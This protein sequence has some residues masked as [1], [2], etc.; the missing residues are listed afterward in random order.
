MVLV[1]GARHTGHGGRTAARHR[2]TAR[3]RKRYARG[4]RW[5]RPRWRRRGD[6]G[7]GEPGHQ[8]NRLKDRRASP[9][10]YE[11]SMAPIPTHL[12]SGGFLV[13]DTKRFVEYFLMSARYEIQSY[14]EV[15]Q[16]VCAMAAC[17]MIHESGGQDM[18]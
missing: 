7:H 3:R 16:V 6:E 13:F 12:G 10:P 8:L 1:E 4:G 2:R 9:S 17:S 15:E 18:R 14:H 5:T 11:S